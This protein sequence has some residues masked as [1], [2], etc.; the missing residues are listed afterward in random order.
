VIVQTAGVPEC[1][2]NSHSDDEENHEARLPLEHLFLQGEFV[3]DARRRRLWWQW[4][5]AEITRRG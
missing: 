5:R 2:R 4:N 1:H 3:E